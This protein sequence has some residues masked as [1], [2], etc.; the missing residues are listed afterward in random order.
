MSKIINL[1]KETI[2]LTKNINEKGPYKVKSVTG[3]SYI[4][5][6]IPPE[7]RTLKNLPRNSKKKPKVRFQ[8]WLLL[9]NT[10]KS[11][12]SVGQAADGAW[13]G[14]SHRAINGFRVGDTITPDKIGTKNKK[15]SYVIKT[16]KEAF[17]HAERFSKEVS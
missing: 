3:K 11:R 2:N 7:K 12:Y 8:D 16:E 6:N 9:K 1:I 14:W 4:Y 13:Y 17:E 10:S 5:T 15:K